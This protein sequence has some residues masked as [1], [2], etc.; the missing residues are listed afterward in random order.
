LR[1]YQ[2]GFD[3]VSRVTLDRVAVEAFFVEYSAT[4][5]QLVHMDREAPVRGYEA[6]DYAKRV[7]HDEAAGFLCEAVEHIVAIDLADAR[8]MFTLLFLIGTDLPEALVRYHR[9]HR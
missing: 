7:V 6:I 4:I 2:D 8:R 5:A 9:R 3:C 1:L